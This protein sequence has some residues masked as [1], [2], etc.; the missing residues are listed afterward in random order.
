MTAATDRARVLEEFGYTARQAHFLTLVALHGGYFLRRQY[1]AF[2]GRAHGQA[3][4]R[5][6]ANA[7]AREHIR[8]L[9]CGRQG[10]LFHV[11]ARPLY[12]AIGEEHNRNRRSAEWEAV[13]RKLMA[14][15]FVL[16]HPQAEFWATE[17]DKVTLLRGLGI[18]VDVWPAKRYP[19]R[20]TGGPTTTRYFVDKMPW[21][22]EPDDPHLW[23][24]YVGAER[25]LKGLETFLVQ[26]QHLL[27]A[28]PSGVMY[29]APRV[30]RSVIQSVFN[31]AIG[32]M[33]STA[34]SLMAFLEYCRL[35]REVEASRFQYL[36]VAE[37]Q[38]FRALRSR[39]AARAFDDLYAR[40]LRS[41][42]GS[43]WS[44][45]VA[46][47]APPPCALQV[48]ELGIRYDEQRTGKRATSHESQVT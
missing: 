4:V 22:R 25:T 27:K 17:E 41:G 32:N 15:D 19:S 7:V 42:D 31:K 12:A 13:T 39:F 38:Q 14:L 33:Q 44:T 8:V 11:C 29:V 18:P 40:W 26:Y 37:L 23:F 24:T 9:P 47:A 5:F 36:K 10:H 2:T 34:I 16:A 28:V 6:I 21:Y 3:T 1:V 30:V 35:R 20:R 45:E 43:I 48:H 46:S